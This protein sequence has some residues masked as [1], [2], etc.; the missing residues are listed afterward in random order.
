MNRYD[1]PIAVRVYRWLLHLYPADF[2]LRFGEEAAC[3]FADMYEDT[4]HDKGV[5][6]AIR[7]IVV[8]F[9][10]AV[11]GLLFSWTEDPRDCGARVAMEQRNRRKEMGRLSHD[12]RNAF[13]ALHKTPGF[14]LTVILL[15]AAGIGSAT[16]VFSVV[17]SVILRPLPYPE[18]ESLFFV[19]N[20]N[21]SPADFRDWQ[22]EATSVEAWAAIR[23][24]AVDL[25]GGG[26]PEKVTAGSINAE[27]MKVLGA[28]PA[29]GRAFVTSDFRPKSDVVMLSYGIWQRRWGGDPDV[30]GKEVRLDNRPMRIVGV[31]S[32]DFRVPVVL[33]GSPELFMPL[34]L[35]DPA[36]QNRGLHVLAVA[37]KLRPGVAI[38][39]ARE[40]MDA[41]ANRLAERYPETHRFPDGTIATFPLVPLKEALV[42]GIRTPFLLLLASV[43]FLLLIACANVANLLLARTTDRAHEFAL[44]CALGARRTNLAG[45]LI[46]ESLIL[47]GMGGLLGVLLAFAGVRVFAATAPVVLL[48]GAAVSIDLRVLLFATAVA[49]ATGI[50]FGTVPAVKA[51]R[52]DVSLILKEG[53]TQTT[54]GSSRMSFQGALVVVELALSLTLLTGAGLL[55]N[56]FLHIIQTHIGF[57]PA[58]MV[59]AD[60]QFGNRYTPQQI[61]TFAETLMEQL[62]TIP[63]TQAVLEGVQL[64]FESATGGRCCWADGFTLQESGGKPLVAYIQPVQ[65][66]YFASLG[67]RLVSGRD[68]QADDDVMD[69][70]PIVVNEAFAASLFGV[71]N[72]IGKIVRFSRPFVGTPESSTKDVGVIVGVAEDM[73]YFSYTRKA[74]P[75]VYVPYRKFG[76]DFPFLSIGIR[77]TAQTADVVQAIRKTIWDLEPSLPISNIRTMNERLDAAVAGERFYST[78]LATFSLLA[79][80]LTAGG[81]YATFLYSVRRRRREIGIRMALGAGRGNIA[82]LVLKRASRLIVIGLGLGLSG[83]LAAGKAL[84]SMV[85]GITSHDPGTIAAASAL[86]TLV[87]LVACLIPAWSASKADSLE[88]LREE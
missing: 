6:A 53:S 62:R 64:P 87:A 45:Q 26:T 38:Q 55:F 36:I 39:Q 59:T 16:A 19:Q 12:I 14:A 82:A 88:T 31:I 40:E 70:L 48:R 9:L 11:S 80:L 32:S 66:G 5:A 23:R 20:G 51:S 21:H 7:L 30:L 79:L 58:R 25:T 81:I 44:R 84:E 18:P 83:V 13:R 73:Q 57:D 76:G 71:T 10:R 8:S 28:R 22:R 85:F 49:I 34:D 75:E 15:I 63:G 60:L 54:T 41:I 46:T 68:L 47:A 69:P 56:T 29:L 72:A 86:L 42:R 24:Q 33:N 35:T 3:V 43:G 52:A 61:L 4:L 65:R 77:S 37:A 50:L 67:N 78:L 74:G 17:D 2:R 1:R 27:F